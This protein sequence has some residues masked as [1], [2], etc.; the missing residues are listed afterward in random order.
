MIFLQYHTLFITAISR[1]LSK[2]SISPMQKTAT[3]QL[4]KLV[5]KEGFEKVRLQVL[6]TLTRLKQ[7]CCHPA[8]FAKDT[9]EAGDSA[10]YEM[11]LDLVGGLIEA[12]HK[13]VVFSQYTRMLAIM[14]QDLQKMG[15]NI[16]YLD[17]SS[18]KPHEHCE[19]V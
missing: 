18:K 3:E 1:P 13:T 12:K 15:A 6:A 16:A 17:G 11:F 9:V 8:I 2:S 19:A 4:V 10:K 5:E 14:K 7:I